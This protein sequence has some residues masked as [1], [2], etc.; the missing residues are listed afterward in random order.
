MECASLLWA[1][2][3][4]L[5]YNW[6]KNCILSEEFINCFLFLRFQHL[7]CFYTVEGQESSR[8]VRLRL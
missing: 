1:T 3:C 8:I 5:R 7:L 4:V 6:L 2:Y